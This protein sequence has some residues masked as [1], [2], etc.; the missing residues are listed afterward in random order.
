MRVLGRVICDVSGPI[1]CHLSSRCRR[2]PPFLPPARAP[3]SLVLV[4][5]LSLSPLPPFSLPFPSFPFSSSIRLSLSTTLDAT[6]GRNL[7]RATLSLPRLSS[8]NI[9]SRLNPCDCL[10]PSFLA[11]S[12]AGIFSPPPHPSRV[13]FLFVIVPASILDPLVSSRS[14]QRRCQWRDRPFFREQTPFSSEIISR[15][16]RMSLPVT[17]PAKRQ[18]HVD[19]SRGRERLNSIGGEELR[20]ARFRE[21]EAFASTHEWGMGKN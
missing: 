18:S 1:G 10:P 13:R 15:S 19:S 9:P 12:L 17:L 20:A 8:R 4:L 11:R 14:F 5:S 2:V 21:A 6:R 16:P 7:I 3:S